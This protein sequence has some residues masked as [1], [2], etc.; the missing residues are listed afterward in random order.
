M[1]RKFAEKRLLIASHNAGKM[2]EIAKLVRAYGIEVEGAAARGLVEPDETGATFRANAELKALAAAGAAKVPALS[3]DSGLVVFALGGAPG[4][5]SA[6]WA[7]PAKDFR[8][9]MER[10]ERELQALGPKTSRRAEFVAVLSLAWPDGHVEIFEGRV[11]GRL[12]WP[13]TGDNGFG[14]DPMFLP[15]GHERTFGEMEPEEKHAISHRAL[16]FKQLADACFRG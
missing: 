2:R 7:G 16:A 15:D 3:D 13:P 12:E 1:P 6:R 4:V 10:V 14:Y 8:V 9:A 5:L 11:G